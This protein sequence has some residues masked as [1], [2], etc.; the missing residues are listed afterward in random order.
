[1]TINFKSAGVNVTVTNLTGPTAL[2]P[3]GLPA[4]IVGTSE[5]GPAFVPVT[6]PTM[7]DFMVKFGKPVDGACNGPLAVSEWLRNA[8]ACTFLRVLGIGDGNARTTSG[9]NK[10]KVTNAGFVVGDQQPQTIYSGALGNN[11]EANVGGTL[12]RTYFLGAFM[13]ESNGSTF[14]SDAGLSGVGVPMIRGVL[15]AAS[16]VIVSLSNSVGGDN[17]APDVTANSATVKGFQTGSVVLSSGKQEFVMFLNGH[18]AANL[19]YPNIITASFDPTAPNYFGDIFNKDPYNLEKAGYCLYSHFDIYPSVATV[20]GASAIVA[21]S[22]GLGNERIAFVITGSQTRNSGTIYAPNFENFEDR[23]RTAFSPWVTSQRFGGKPKNLFK[24]HSLSD[25]SGPNEQVKISIEAITP[26]LNGVNPYGTFDLLVRDATDTDKNKKVLERWTGLSLDPSSNKYV[27]RV[28]GDYH[29]FYNLEASTDEQKIV[30]NGDYPN[31]SKYIRVEM[32]DE[33]TNGEMDPSALPIGFRGLQHFMTSGSAPMGAYSDTGILSSTNPWYKLVQ[34]PVPF[35][36]NLS[37]GSSPNN[38]GD[39]GL[40]WGVQFE[41]IMSVTESNSTTVFNDSLFGFTKYYPDF[42]TDWQDF[43]TY[44]NEGTSDTAQNGI[45]D[46]DRFNN[47]FFSLDKIKVVYVS[48]SNLPDLNNL[49]RWSYVRNG[50]IS[51]DTVNFT[52]ALTMSDLSDPT[53]RQVCKFTFPLQGGFNGTRIFDEKSNT[54]SNEAI[55]EEMNN[56]NR[57][58]SQ[59]PTV[60]TYQKTFNILQDTS[61]LDM[62]LLAIPGIRHRYLTDQALAVVENRFDAMYLMD[63]EQMDT[64]NTDVTATTQVVSVRNTI[65]N[66]QERGIN[67]SFGSAYFPDCIVRDTVNNV[68]RQVPPSVIALGA[69]SKNDAVAYP[70]YAPAGFTRGALETTQEAAVQLSRNNMDDLYVNNINP[71][72]AFPGSDGTVIWGQKTMLTSE[73]SLERV[74]VRRLM[75]SLRRQVRKVANRFLFEPNKES[76]LERF[77]QLVQPILK[78]IQDQKGVDQYLVRI[79]TST[80]TQADIENKTIRGKIFIVPTK[81]LEFLSLDFTLTNQGNFEIA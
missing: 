33:V 31:V 34:P 22:G 4:G 55:V 37:K 66:F 60:Q 18:K 23:Y 40:Y 32:A 64:N 16:G 30:I 48:S 71:I 41:Q 78:K 65:N 10:G 35:R 42:Q 80:T 19:S 50:S 72:V 24:I 13:S 51:T 7:Q 52:R 11:Q 73:S 8:Q 9:L 69:Y 20:T 67:S 2:S 61:E 74:N 21:A 44:E 46:A 53:V 28:I 14:L 76:T 1:M 6:V 62:Q 3:L 56:S 81:T 25:G 63:I 36:L 79:D 54:L 38:T 75:L 17:T 57:G 77:Q 5:K 49:Q 70:W 45:I 68:I 29:T 47:N 58:F 59:G 15:M 39:K 27:A 12:G 43:V 26:A